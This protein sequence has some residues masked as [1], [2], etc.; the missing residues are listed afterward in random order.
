MKQSSFVCTQLNG[1]KYY[2]LIVIILL[3][4]EDK[5]ELVLFDL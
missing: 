5:I 1:F 4:I 2:Y 3:N